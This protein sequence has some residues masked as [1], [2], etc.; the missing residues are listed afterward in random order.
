MF[1]NFDFGKG[2]ISKFINFNVNESLDYYEQQFSYKQDMLQ[3]TYDNNYVIDVG[4]YQDFDP[5]G[6]FK[7]VIIK[8]ND[9][10]N[11]V[12]IEKCTNTKDLS[13]YMEKFTSYIQDLLCY[14][15]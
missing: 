9:W 2:V 3:I 11:P 12:L 14:N 10:W 5:N 1:E 4:W 8:D 6:F 13:V 7:I 15:Q